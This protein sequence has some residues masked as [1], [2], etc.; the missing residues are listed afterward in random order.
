MIDSIVVYRI[1]LL[2]LPN[3]DSIEYWRGAEKQ[4]WLQSQ[5]E[6]MKVWRKRWFVL[7]QGYLFRFLGSD[8]SGETWHVVV[9]CLRQR[10]VG[11]WRYSSSTHRV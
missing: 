1:V 8:V 7:K 10:A 9:L 6:V 3:A 4:G 11:T 5:A 2:Q